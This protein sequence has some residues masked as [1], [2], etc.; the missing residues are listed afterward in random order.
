M[1][2]FHI[3]SQ[4]ISYNVNRSINNSSETLLTFEPNTY[5]YGVSISGSG[6]LLSDTSYIRVVLIDNQNVQW[7]IYERNNLYATEGST[8]FENASFETSLMDGIVPESIFAVVD[9]A[10]LNITTIKNNQTRPSRC[11]DVSR[12]SDSIFIAKNLQ[13]VRNINNKLSEYKKAWRAD[14][15]FLSN[16]R[17][18][19]RKKIFGDTLPNLQGWDYYA[20]GLLFDF[21]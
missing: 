14:T 15:T 5:S 20:Y 10:V 19:Q 2:G 16:L 11:A 7:L 21:G 4:T 9:N 17:Y 3:K 1:V 18:Q 12:L 13:I 8:S 6:E